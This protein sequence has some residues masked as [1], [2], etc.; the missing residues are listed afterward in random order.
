MIRVVVLAQGSQKRMGSASTLPKQLLPLPAC[1]DVP[2]IVRTM[3]QVLRGSSDVG[4]LDVVTTSSVW[5]H[6]RQSF[7]ETTAAVYGRLHN[8]PR[9]PEVVTHT[10]LQDPGNSSLKGIARYFAA[11]PCEAQRTVVLLGDVVYSWHCLDALVLGV[12]DRG[13]CFAGTSDLAAGK[14]EL[15]GVAWELDR[16]EFMMRRLEESLQ[17][18]PPFETYQPGQLRRWLVGLDRCSIAD[19]VAEYSRNGCY[20]AFDDYTMDVDVPPHIY[21]LRAASRAAADDDL[22]RGLDWERIASAHE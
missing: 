10:T 22:V 17:R 4:L 1:N 7:A 8:A 3:R 11:K 5:E 6:A 21:K 2:I 15:W 16:E 9:G 18:H 20:V 13:I 19:R 14:G 12:A